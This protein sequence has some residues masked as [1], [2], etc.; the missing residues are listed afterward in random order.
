LAGGV[1]AQCVRLAEDADHATTVVDHRHRRE[2]VSTV[3][4]SG[5]VVQVSR[6][7]AGWL[8]T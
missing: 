3:I 7:I 4:A 5:T 1:G 6:L 2:P 8:M